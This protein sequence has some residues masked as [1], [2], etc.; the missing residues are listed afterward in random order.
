MLVWFVLLAVAIANGAAREALIVPYAGDTAGRAISTVSLALLI[1]LLSWWTIGWI[2]PRSR[3][4]AW[5]VGGVWVAL[6]LAFEFLGGHYLFGTP[7]TRLLEDYN[8]VRGRIWV[9]VL[10]TTAAA[11]VIAARARIRV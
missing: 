11:P 6:T 8:V 5:R 10:A 1:L 2:R 7:W 4:D 3:A 9:L